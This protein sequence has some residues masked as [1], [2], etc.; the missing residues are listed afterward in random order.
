MVQPSCRASHTTLIVLPPMCFPFGP[1]HTDT[2]FCCR[3]GSSFNAPPQKNMDWLSLEG[4]HRPV[5]FD[6]KSVIWSLMSGHNTILQLVPSAGQ[7]ECKGRNQWCKTNFSVV[8]SKKP[9]LCPSS[10]SH[11]S[12]N[13]PLPPF[14]CSFWC[15]LTIHP[16]MNHN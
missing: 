1:S 9:P 5:A 15:G 7:H 2:W 13:E 3:L 11:Q 10:S 8:V 6:R 14:F 16:D 4:N 12:Q